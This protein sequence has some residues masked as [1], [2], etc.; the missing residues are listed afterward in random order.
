MPLTPKAIYKDYKNNDLG[1]KF[2]VDLLL[3][4]IDHAETIETRKESI[5]MLGKI[6]PNDVK[7]YKFLEHLIISDTNEEVRAIT[8]NVLRNNYLEKALTPISWVLEHEK[9]LKCLIIGVK[10]LRDIDNNESRS[11]LIEKLDIFYRKEDKFNLKSITG[12]RI[13]N[14]FSNKELSEIL[15]N[16]FIISFLIS[17]FGYV[18]YKFDSS[19]LITELDLSNVESFEP[20][21]RKLE[22]LIESILSLKYIKKLDLRFN[23]LNRIPKLINFSMEELDLSYNKI[24]KLP[25]FNKLP[26]V[27]NLNLKSNRIRSLPKSIGSFCSL[28]SLN[29][30]NNM[31]TSLPSLFNNLTCLKTLDL[32]GNKFDKINVNLNKS[33]KHLELGWNNFNLFP[34]VI[35][36]LS[37]LVKLGMGGN[38]LKEIP[39]WIDTF[40]D[41]KDLDLY[42]NK[43]SRLPSSIGTLN[44]LE[45]LNLRNN[46]LSKLPESFKNLKSLKKLNL[47]WNNF[48]ILPDCI[49]KLSSLE[50]L[51]LWGNKL[52]ELPESISLLSNLKILDLHF[53]KFDKL[54]FTVQKLKQNKDLTI[55]F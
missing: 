36:V 16:Y 50:E 37:Q 48:K 24:V 26:S 47:S 27:K 23:R 18:K 30:R 12:K 22:N 51:N 14:K 38:K 45:S 15:I 21:T 54:S 42:D 53:N 19:A 8:C 46:N 17:T 43:I 1:K 28:E 32:H 34:D 39:E 3:N 40:Q 25:K 52:E 13:F 20:G 31:L 49:M 29:L 33:L 7:T 5:K 35:K 4:I 10:T 6:Q 11:L 2:S 55:K 41:L 9:S 44:S